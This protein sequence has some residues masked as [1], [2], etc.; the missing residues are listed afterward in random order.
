VAGEPPRALV[1]AKGAT[2]AAMASVS[3]TVRRAV[4]DA[5]REGATMGASE[6]RLALQRASSKAERAAVAAKEAAEASAA[7][8]D[9]RRER[10]EEKRR[11][12]E[13]RLESY[14]R[15]TELEKRRSDREAKTTTSRQTLEPFDDGAEF[16][17][18]REKNKNLRAR[19]SAMATEL[20]TLRTAAAR[21]KERA[22]ALE[23]RLAKREVSRD[24][25]IG[26]AKREE[27]AA[28][29]RVLHC[30]KQIAAAT[31]TLASERA[32]ARD[33]K[34]A[35]EV[36][37]RETRAC[38][39]R[40]LEALREDAR[41]LASDARDGARAVAADFLDA[42]RLIAETSSAIAA[43]T[44]RRLASGSRR[45]E[46]AEKRVLELDV[47]ALDAER[48]AWN[49]ENRASVAEA[50]LAESHRSAALE[51][52]AADEAAAKLA[53]LTVR[54]EED[55]RANVTA[56]RQRD[57]AL[58][59]ALKAAESARKEASSASRSARVAEAE[60]ESAWKAAAEAE[61]EI[62]ISASR[63]READARGFASRIR[64][65]RVRYF[66][67]TSDHESRP[68]KARLDVRGL[69]EA[70]IDFKRRRDEARRAERRERFSSEELAETA[71]KTEL[72]KMEECVLVTLSGDAMIR[73]GRGYNCESPEKCAS[74]DPEAGRTKR[75]FAKTK[76]DVEKTLSDEDVLEMLNS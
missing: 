18:L 57:D 29:E 32:S 48:R 49:A 30:E 74:P 37:L 13:K 50:K 56:T 72:E 12:A 73:R 64:A 1:S 25:E 53:A 22:D 3:E 68:I 5:R 62:E 51:R 43:G 20:A 27:R 41:L 45:A 14:E 36:I 2:A 63:R 24:A 55:R 9:E 67:E 47:S 7:E 8:A 19:T 16:S 6:A 21:E 11:I 34:S 26:R 4:T 33:A 66:H 69:V 59:S 10:A 65:L 15:A 54:C 28:L 61:R 44:R 70:M 17:R 39:A 76:T 31:E 46:A 52:A 58:E 71:A 75:R 60:A 42:R 35:Y 38:A 40:A 23:L